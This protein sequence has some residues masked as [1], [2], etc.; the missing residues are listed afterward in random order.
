MRFLRSFGRWLKLHGNRV[1][2]APGWHD[3][4]GL[5]LRLEPLECRQLLAVG[6]A[7]LADVNPGDGSSFPGEFVDVGPTPFFVAEHDT[8]GREL[9]KT[10]GTADG[11]V[12]VKDLF[13]GTYTFYDNDHPN[14][15]QP[16]NLTNLNGTLFFT[17]VDE[18]HGRELWKSDGTADGTVMVK[19]LFSGS[20]SQYGSADVPNSSSP[21]NLTNVDGT[22]FFT[23]DDGNN[24]EELWK[25]DGT[26]AGTVIVKDIFTGEG[27]Q[28]DDYSGYSYGPNSSSPKELTNV[29]GTLF[30]SA[31]DKNGGSELWRTDGTEAGTIL[32]KDIF[33]GSFPYYGTEHPYQSDPQD[34]TSAGGTLFFTA[35][36]HANGLELWKSD[37]T[38]DGTVIVKD[39]NTGSNSYGTPLGSNPSSLLYHDG[40]LYFTADDG[41]NGQEL[42]KSDGTAS[43]TV[44]VKDIFTGEGPQYDYYTGDTFGPNSSYP[45]QLTVAGGTLFFT[46]TD[47]T[48]GRELWKTDGTTSGT[49]L[50]E[51][52]RPQAENGPAAGSSP[53]YL[54]SVDGTLHFAADDGSNGPELWSSDG[55]T[56]GTFMV[57]DILAG[58]AGSQPTA[59]ADVGA[60]LFFSVNDGNSGQEPWNYQPATIDDWGTL[61]GVVYQDLNGNRARDANEGGMEDIVVFADDNGN[62]ELDPQELS[63]LTDA[64]GRYSFL[65]P[66]GSYRLQQEQLSGFV[67]TAPLDNDADTIGHI[68]SIEFGEVSDGLDFGNYELVPPAK[69]DLLPANDS[70]VTDDDVTNFNN[71]FPHSAL[72]FLIAGVADGAQVFVYAGDEQIG[73]GFA[74]GGNALV[75]TYGEDP[76]ADGTHEITAV[77]VVSGVEK[78]GPSQ[79]LLL[80]VDTI[81]PAGITTTPPTFAALDEA[82]PYDA[83]SPDE[84]T[85]GVTYLLADAPSGATI[86]GSGVIDWAPTQSQI[87]PQSF[88]VRVT[89]GAGNDSAQ[90]FEV[91]VLG[92]IPAYP[93]TYQFNEDEPF[94]ATVETGVLANDGDGSVALSATLLTL[95]QHGELVFETDGSFIYTPDEH[96]FGTDRFTYYADD[97]SDESNEASATLT[98]LPVN[99]PPTAGDDAYVV[100]EDHTLDV[101]ATLGVLFNDFDVEGATLAAV[102][103]DQPD[104][105]TLALNPNG[106]FSYTPDG[107]YFGED[108]FTYRAADG[109]EDSEVATVTIDVD[110]VND[111]PVAVADSYDVDEDAVLSVNAAEG[112]LDNDT[113]AEGDEL[114]AVVTTD[115]ANGTLELNS[116][117]SFEY[118]SRADFFGEDTFSYRASDSNAES[119]A[120]TV[121]ISIAAQ[122]DPPAA[123]NDEYE[124]T[125]DGALQVLPVLDNDDTEPDG[126]QSLAITDVSDGSAGGTIEVAADGAAIEYTPAPGFFGTE[127]FTYTVEDADELTDEA[128]VTVT[129]AEYVP[130]NSSIS[131]FVFCDTDDDGIRDTGES[132][133]PGVVVTLNGTD[134]QDNVVEASALTSSDGS[135]FFGEL[136]PGTYEVTETQP[137]AFRDGK[138]SV[139]SL[140]G[141]ADDDHLSG[142][143]LADDDH[144]TQYNF[145]ELKLHLEFASI[146]WFL[147]STPPVE[148]LL[149]EIVADAEEAAGDSELAAAIRDGAN[150]APP[151]QTPV[152]DDD[153]YQIGENDTLTV[154]VD[155]GLLDNDNDADGDPMTVKLVEAPAHGD[156]DL[157]DNGSFTYTPDHDFN[158]TDSFVYQASDGSAHSGEA[159]VE[160]TVVPANDAPA[161]KQLA[162]VTLQ[163]GAPLHVPL[164]GFDREGE[165]LTYTADSSNA[166]LVSTHIPENNRS[167]RISVADYG[168]MVLELFEDRVPDVTGPIIEYAEDG[169]YE[170]VI[171]HRVID[172]FMIQGGNPAYTGGDTSTLVSFDDQ[173]HV[174]LQHTGTG[175]LAMAKAGDDTNSSQFYIIEGPTRYLDFNHSVFGQLVEGE[176]VREAISNVETGSGDRP[177]TDVVIES[178]EIFLDRENAVLM[179]K[180]P[181]GS[182]GEADVTVTVTD[183]STNQYQRTFHVTVQPDTFNGGPFLEPVPEVQTLID[184]PVTFQLSAIDVEGDPVFFDA[185]VP[186][187]AVY[188]VDV[189]S[190]TGEVTFT[191]PPGYTGEI[192]IEVR[193]KPLISSDTQDTHD[194]QHVKIEVLPQTESLTDAALEN[195]EDWI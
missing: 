148:V 75:T 147:S 116:D 28:Y 9:W 108:A 43:G 1:K 85:P 145:G 106:S 180:A 190:L 14:S 42:W 110:A 169:L 172:N 27:P 86:D 133:V 4:L 178:M 166:S 140:G 183:E 164:D 154:S 157:N 121:T 153:A 15:S 101:N 88:D 55:T 33:P 89:D 59:L 184:N 37:G 174:D 119:A 135:Y 132:G 82:Y 19:D 7:L 189:E 167:M 131:G 21:Q 176:D 48:H 146:R 62:G 124:S 168:D 23:A 149:R 76:L 67:Q 117:G 182:S 123:E 118:K 44:M 127:T 100:D 10:D 95:P 159:T 69:P 58:P 35:E 16:Q 57:E 144:A 8:T 188:S 2:T 74:G 32:V 122:P 94:T 87:G 81:A 151:N 109:D 113:D 130:A 79:P 39:I 185:V 20:T 18:K 53:N 138:D 143:V 160:I 120:T 60:A 150:Q 45:Q 64:D 22:L 6:P 71:E 41:Q 181:E 77:Q 51:D 29:D 98:I 5:P 152:A 115:P 125:Q 97:G 26:A 12:I 90:T 91:F 63:A 72:K 142:I 139:G 103:V 70:G 136:R 40:T 158:G 171:F 83:D 175:V 134:D 194:S 36:D 13:P 47:E 61:D 112:L 129:V 99:D 30:F 96:F 141:T 11:T 114:T 73:H 165:K 38:T 137:A 49:V 68:A 177:V 93:D 34:L 192:E 24:G 162:D 50:V 56:L 126:D 193:V 111:P 156:V 179:L 46:A 173:F 52:I 107:N 3:S 195:G 161:L 84:G 54:T 25:S 187:S 92:V 191:P 66:P 104:H 128:T 102:A 155:A 78:S 170:D 163:A 80:T 31:S 186:D 65:V 17:A 105:G